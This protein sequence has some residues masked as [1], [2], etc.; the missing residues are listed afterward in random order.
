MI[1]EK[2]L[3]K[4]TDD[5][6]S[7]SYEDFPKLN[8]EV[9]NLF[10]PN[11]CNW[12]KGYAFRNLPNLNAIWLPE[13]LTVIN[14]T[15]FSGL[16]NLEYLLVHDMRTDYGGCHGYEY[17]SSFDGLFATHGVSEW[18]NQFFKNYHRKLNIISVKK[19]L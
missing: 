7:V 16:D 15:A 6:L 4:L 17:P 1:N 12:I 18:L 5:I 11:G 14:K 2:K 13:T 10:I 8:E 19:H 3:I 9:N